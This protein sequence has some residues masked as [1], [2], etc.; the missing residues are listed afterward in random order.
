MI[1]IRLNT[2]I[3]EVW[4]ESALYGA[5]RNSPAMPGLIQ[6][7]TFLFNAPDARPIDRECP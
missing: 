5:E 7:T 2:Y 3:D 4:G 1:Y 6:L